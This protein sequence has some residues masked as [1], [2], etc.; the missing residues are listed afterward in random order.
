[1]ILQAKYAKMWT[2]LD[3]AGN[4]IFNSFGSFFLWYGSFHSSVDVL[5]LKIIRKK[6]FFTSLIKFGSF[7]ADP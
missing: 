3:I 7:R 4:D 6:V 5:A 2:L 1:V